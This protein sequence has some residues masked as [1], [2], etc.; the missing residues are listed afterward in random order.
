MQGTLVNVAAII[1]GVVLGCYV[2]PEFSDDAR[3]TVISGVALSVVLIGLHMALGFEDLLVV[4]ISLAI[5]GAA[6]EVM[7]LQGLLD[8]LGAKMQDAVGEGDGSRFAQGFV[9]A[10]LVYC[11]GP[12]AI[13]G[14]IQSGMHGDHATLYAKSMLDGI[15]AVVFSS[16]MGVGVVGAAG[17]VLIYQGSITLM[18][19]RLSL[20]LT[21]NMISDLTA[22]G[23]LIIVAI[24]L[25]MLEVTDIRLA[26]LLPAIVF[27]PVIVHLFGMVATYLP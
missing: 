22:T 14:A 17:S 6:G 7:G 5:G 16:A 4:I 10:T 26:N 18:A 13:M 3:E 1:V 2:V 9:A 27:S 24:G 21:E 15:T 23:G 11:V 12:M 25:N 20:L 8:R 19:S